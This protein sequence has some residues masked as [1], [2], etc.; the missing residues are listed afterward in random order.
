MLQ[1][2]SVWFTMIPWFF[3]YEVCVYVFAYTCGHGHYWKC[4]WFKLYSFLQHLLSFP[5]VYVVMNAA[6][7]Y[8]N[9]NITDSNLSTQSFVT[10]HNDLK[11]PED[12]TMSV[13]NSLRVLC[14]NGLIPGWRNEVIY[15]PCII[16]IFYGVDKKLQYYT[17]CLC[18][19]L[20]YA[21]WTGL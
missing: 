16:S 1:R 21:W 8:Q 17:C 12:R 13:N 20:C 11:T 6:Q 9:R 2:T 18:H 15:F 14:E 3:I 5:K 7:D 10:L 4:V 19:Y